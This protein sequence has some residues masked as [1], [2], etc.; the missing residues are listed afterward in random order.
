[1][2]SKKR[3]H[4][5]RD[6]AKTKRK[7]TQSKK[8]SVEQPDMNQTI[9]RRIHQVYGMFDDGIPIKDIPVFYENSKKT[10]NFCKKKNITYRMWNFKDANSLVESLDKAEQGKTDPIP[11]LKTWK[12]SRFKQQPILR[13]DF[14]RYCILYDQGGIYVD[15][16]IHPIKPLTR[17]FAKPYFFVTWADDKRQLPYNALLGTYKHN[18][19]YREIIREC[20]KSFQEKKHQEIYKSWKG[21]FVFQTTGHYMLKRVLKNYQPNIERDILLIYGK[22]RVK[23]IGN[24]E[25]ALFEDAN[26]S[27]WYEGDK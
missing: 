20:C 7:T 1:M 13:A 4:R 25:K 27:V 16:D 23:P 18:P 22:G 19:L 15:C 2:R 24:K 11:F 6:R 3:T 8:H 26:A 9:P 12:D 5:V 14:I 10:K 17:L 21:R